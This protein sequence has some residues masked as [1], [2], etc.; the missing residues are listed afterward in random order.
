MSA[1]FKALLNLFQKIIPSERQTLDDC[2]TRYFRYHYNRFQPKESIYKKFSYSFGPGGV[3]IEKG[4]YPSLAAIGTKTV[5]NV[6][7]WFCGGSLISLNWVLS[8]AHC[9]ERATQI[10]LGTR[11]PFKREKDK[12]TRQEFKI[13]ETHRFNDTVGAYNASTS[14]YDLVLFKLDRKVK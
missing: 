8:A 13:I 7:D 5:N 11:F 3:S 12:E 4:E 9:A 6:D 14:Y 2:E 10:L 1:D